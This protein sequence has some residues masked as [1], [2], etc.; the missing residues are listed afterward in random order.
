MRLILKSYFK[1]IFAGLK[2]INKVRYYY[3]INRNL[4]LKKSDFN[5]LFFYYTFF[6]YFNY[7]FWHFINQLFI[8]K[9]FLYIYNSTN[10]NIINNKDIVFFLF[11]MAIIG[12]YIYILKYS[13]TV[14]IILIYI[15]L[16]LLIFPHNLS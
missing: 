1:Y 4:H 9:K 14:C 7:Y 11:F 13:Y 8:S 15:S 10:N 6:F 3:F 16:A 5:L 2:F 12:N